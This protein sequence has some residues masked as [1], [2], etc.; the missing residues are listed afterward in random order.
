MFL[1]CPWGNYVSHLNGLDSLVIWFICWHGKCT[2]ISVFHFNW[3]QLTLYESEKKKKQVLKVLYLNRERCYL[4]IQKFRVWFLMLV[5]DLF[6]FFFSFFVSSQNWI[7]A[8]FQDHSQ[9]LSYFLFL[10]IY[11]CLSLMCYSNWEPSSP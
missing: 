1:E 4:Q 5:T 11:Y 6:L 3:L 10:L 9:N 7:T 8:L 2:R